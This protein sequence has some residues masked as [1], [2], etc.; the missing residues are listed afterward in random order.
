ML[1]NLFASLSKRRPAEDARAAHRV[2]D[3]S[4]VIG[5]VTTTP[6]RRTVAPGDAQTAEFASARLRVLIP[7]AQLARRADVSVE[8]IPLELL[9][10]ARMFESEPW[11]THVVLGKMAAG[12]VQANEALFRSVLDTLHRV[13]GDVR[14]LADFSD[15]YAALAEPLGAPFLRS[16]QATLLEDHD[17][18][19]P[20]EALRERLASEARGSVTVVEDPYESPAARAPRASASDPVRLC[21]FGTLGEAN[22]ELVAGKLEQLARAM[23]DRALQFEVGAH[24]SR[25][26]M[27]RAL[28]ARLAAAHPRTGVAFTEWSLERTWAAIDRCDFVVLPQDTAGAAGRVKSPNRLVEAIRGGR[29]AL[30]SPIPSY[31][32]LA[33]YAWVGEDLG[34]GLRWALA[35]PADALERVRAGQQVVEARFASAAIGAQWARALGLSPAAGVAQAPAA[36]AEGAPLRRLNL[37]CGHR[38]LDGYVNV[39]VAPARA[40]QPPDVLC[41]L[42][43]LEPF[44]TDSCDEVMAIHVIEHFYRWEVVDLLREW[45]RVL[46]PG[47]RMVLECPNLLTACE[48]LLSNPQAAGPGS[49][50]ERTMW[51]LYGDP[52][53]QD[54][55]MCHRWNYTPDSLREVMAEAGLVNLRQEPAQ[56]KLREPRDMRIVGEKPAAAC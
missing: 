42:R 39:D 23:Q 38:M 35:H 49:A 25:G 6:E 50:S 37:G 29:L 55:L 12:F 27:V 52:E 51:V 13:R 1:R 53:W 7:A 21:W 16:Y 2:G 4:A 40:G 15:D 24:R 30:A 44:A 32:E 20:C 10:D 3:D 31:Q 45:L 18:V 41:D 8:L 34:Q 11:L 56:F 54:P 46:K 36:G 28:G 26:E 17:I 47:G 14:V 9:R 33:Q 5:F 22:F 19:V 48:A 43:R